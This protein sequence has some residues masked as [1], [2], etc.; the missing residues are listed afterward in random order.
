MKLT[1]T[2]SGADRRECLSNAESILD[3][4]KRTSR[5]GS[6]VPP[7]PEPDYNP[8]NIPSAPLSADRWQEFKRDWVEEYGGEKVQPTGMT[9]SEFM[10]YIDSSGW[11]EGEEYN[12]VGKTK[13][14]RQILKDQGWDDEEDDNPLFKKLFE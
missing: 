10:H 9:H 11:R 2:A 3:R 7:P 12:H 13:D 4:I 8:H 6:Y 5:P 14:L 1:I